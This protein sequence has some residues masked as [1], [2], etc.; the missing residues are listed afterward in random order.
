MVDKVQTIEQTSKIFKLQQLL[1]TLLWIVGAILFCVGL[2]SKTAAGT[3]ST[4]GTS[5]IGFLMFIVGFI[6]GIVV[7]FLIWWHHR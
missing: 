6:W 4:S 7:R 3:A 2:G 1:A 5:V